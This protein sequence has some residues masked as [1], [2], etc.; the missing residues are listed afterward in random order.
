M[1][2]GSAFSHRGVVSIPGGAALTGCCRAAAAPGDALVGHTWTLQT[3]AG[4]EIGAGV[5]ATLAFDAAGRATGN[6]GCN[7]FVGN[8]IVLGELIDIAPLAVTRM[9]CTGTGGEG[10][11]GYLA[12]LDRAWAW[13][14]G[15]GNLVLLGRR[16]QELLRVVLAEPTPVP[17]R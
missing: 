8:A 4:C 12:G 1:A 16:R 6:G 17:R 5:S 11:K 10:E 13:C 14:M 9:A 15:D 2:D 7:R 3:I